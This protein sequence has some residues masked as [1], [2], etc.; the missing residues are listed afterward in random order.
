MGGAG[1]ASTSTPAVLSGYPNSSNT[2]VPTGLALKN[3]PGQVTSGPGW[4]YSDG[5]VNVTG[6]GAVFSGY[7]RRGSKDSQLR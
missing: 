7:N 3:V 5:T 1:S 6:A 2:G 4:S